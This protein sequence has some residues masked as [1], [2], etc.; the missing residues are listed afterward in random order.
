MLTALATIASH[1]N[2]L[3][4]SRPRLKSSSLH[5]FLHRNISANDYTT[6]LFKPSKDSTSLHICNEQ[7]IFGFGFQVFVSDDKLFQAF[8]AHFI[9]P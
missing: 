1:I 5:V 3:G 8:L 6:E 2:T 4:C 9:W 7:N